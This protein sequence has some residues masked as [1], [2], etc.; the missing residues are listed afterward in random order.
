MLGSRQVTRFKREGKQYDVILQLAD[1]DRRNSD[2]LKRIHV[3]ASGGHMVPLSNL[4]RLEEGISPRELN[5]FDQRRSATSSANLADRPEERC[6]GKG[7]GR[8]CRSR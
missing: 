5:H 8:K 1:V 3:R 4:V 6:V 7:V 2:D